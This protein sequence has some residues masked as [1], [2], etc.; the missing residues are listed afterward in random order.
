L[1]ARV[2]DG[3]GVPVEVQV[4]RVKKRGA[5][6]LLLNVTDVSERLELEN[7]LHQVQKMEAV[8]RV[9]GGVA[10]DFNN[11]LTTIMSYGEMV[12][13]ALEPKSV[14]ALDMK[15]LLE[16]V[17]TAAILTRQLLAFSRQQIVQP[18]RQSIA[19]MLEATSRLTSRVLGEDMHFELELSGA[20]WEV[21]MD[22]HAFEQVIVNLAVNARDA[23]KSGGTL[24]LR[25]RSHSVS[26]AVQPGGCAEIPPGDYVV[27]EVEDTGAGVDPCA[28]NSIFEPFY[29]TKH[30]GRG[31]GLG[32]STCLGIVE[33]AGGFLWLDSEAKEGARFV[34]YLPRAV[35]AQGEERAE[36]DAMSGTECVLVVE[37]DEGISAL[38]SRVLTKQ[39]YR[40]VTADSEE[41]AMRHV[42]D[43][44]S[45]DLLLSDVVLREGNGR[46]LAERFHMQSPGTKTLLMSGYTADILGTHGVD[47][48]GT[49]LLLKPFSPQQVVRRVR[50]LLDQTQ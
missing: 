7:H 30:T 32:L 39:G 35:L 21:L 44:D 46:E 36:P 8:G 14:S 12:Q 24:T 25:T 22:P 45:V 3:C 40:V 42:S 23:M 11:Q 2:S 28:R 16:A 29:S 10:H 15:V 41:S 48:V 26:E 18:T 37:D 5:P 9:A 17:D 4:T 20:D 50:E 34:M 49:P 31:G 33:Q 1:T 13:E 6:H 47:V 43:E 38:L 19:S 27:L